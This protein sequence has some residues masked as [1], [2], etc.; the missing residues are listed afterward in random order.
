MKCSED[1]LRFGAV[2][3]AKNEALLSRSIEQIFLH[4][5]DGLVVCDI[6]EDETIEER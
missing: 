6:C 5:V 1:Y 2:H 3:G 4:N